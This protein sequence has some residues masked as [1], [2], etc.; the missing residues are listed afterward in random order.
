MTW[1]GHGAQVGIMEGAADQK[2]SGAKG[3]LHWPLE[4]E[5]EEACCRSCSRQPI[6][7]CHAGGIDLRA[8]PA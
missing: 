5:R 7:Q 8:R 3:S 4:H 6:A 2:V 1:H